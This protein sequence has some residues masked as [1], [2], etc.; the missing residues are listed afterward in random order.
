MTAAQVARVGDA[1]DVR[2]PWS[3]V[4][5]GGGCSGVVSVLGGRS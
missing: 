2:L 3:G 5:R 1:A 4:G